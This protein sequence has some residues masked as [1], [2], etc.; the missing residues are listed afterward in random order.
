MT[1]HRQAVAGFLFA[2]VMVLR[3]ADAHS[4]QVGAA[5]G[6]WDRLYYFHAQADRT[7]WDGV[8]VHPQADRGEVNFFNHCASCHQGG[9]EGP[10][11]SGE[12]FFDHWRGDRLTAL[13]RYIKTNM[14]ADH[15]GNLDDWEYLDTLIYI[16]QLN[17]FPPGDTDLMPADL[18]RILIMGADGLRPLPVDSLVYG[19]G[20][21]SQTENGWALTSATALSRSRNF[22]ETEQAYKALEAQPL[23]AGKVRLEGSFDAAGNRGAKVYTKGSLTDQ[24]GESGISVS[25]FRVLSPQCKPPAQMKP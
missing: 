10:I 13:F 12:K 2:L 20:C 9:G 17:G 23:G 4:T 8:Y 16:L 14:P 1:K 7:V 21:L 22:P 6:V 11:L 3:S 19:V 24:N 15:P 5:A 25:A 18:D